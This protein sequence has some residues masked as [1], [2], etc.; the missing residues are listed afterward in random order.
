MKLWNICLE[1]PIK[2]TIISSCWGKEGDYKKK[3]NK[4]PN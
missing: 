1:I 4:S 2:I 3:L